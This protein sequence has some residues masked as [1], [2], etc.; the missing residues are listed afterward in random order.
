MCPVTVFERCS[1]A[2]RNTPSHTQVAPIVIG[3]GREALWAGTIG[4]DW[5]GSNSWPLSVLSL[6]SCVCVRSLRE[7]RFGSD[8]SSLTGSSVCACIMYTCADRTD[9]FGTDWLDICCFCSALRPYIGLP[10]LLQRV[11]GHCRG[12]QVNVASC[13]SGSMFGSNASE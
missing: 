13:H 7:S 9:L 8:A 10:A 2:V 3:P 6:L 12:R 5:V 1:C 11:G 4:G